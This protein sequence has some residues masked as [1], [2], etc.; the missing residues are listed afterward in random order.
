MYGTGLL[1]GLSVTLR[2]MI[3]TFVTDIRKFPRRYFP[4]GN[5]PTRSPEPYLHGTFSIQYPEEK[6]PMW[7]RFRGP[8]IHL[9]DAETGQPRCTACGLCERACPHGCIKVEGEGKGKERKPTLYQYNVG[10]CIF[11]RQCVEAC[12]FNAIE[13]SRF[14]ELAC[15]DKDTLWDL[16]R[17]LELGDKEEIKDQGQFWGET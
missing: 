8:L 10:R 5:H 12:P 15:Y 3:G 17:L 6:V 9:R 7:P 14:Y 16:P 13:L 4:D 2:H 11:C 1:K